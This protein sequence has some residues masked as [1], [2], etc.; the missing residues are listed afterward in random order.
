[1]GK[2]VTLGVRETKD[3]MFCFKAEEVDSAA[4]KGI[5]EV[6]E[7]GL[8]CRGLGECRKWLFIVSGRVRYMND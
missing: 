6:K 5:E 8:H 3:I 7:I 4:L 2:E 1:M